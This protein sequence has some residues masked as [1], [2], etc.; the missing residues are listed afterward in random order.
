MKYTLLSLLLTGCA[1]QPQESPNY[2]VLIFFALVA[3]LGYYELRKIVSLTELKA[4]AYET[5]NPT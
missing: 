4:Y 5:K 1:T 3:A 2:S